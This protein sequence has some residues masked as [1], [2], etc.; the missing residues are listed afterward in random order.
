MKSG[1]VVPVA[2]MAPNALWFFFPAV[3][4]TNDAGVP[5]VAAVFEQVGRI[6]VLVIPFFHTL[7]FRRRHAAVV[8][9]AM[10]AALLVYYA[11]WVRFFADGRAIELFSAPFAGIPVPM[12][13]APSIFLLL[14]SY[15]MRS[16]PMLAGSALFAV[17]HVWVSACSLG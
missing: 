1:F 17:F 9:G 6:A 4:Q 11:C 16:W 7:H 8:A 12:A 10:A 15:L 13:T 3:G 2:L 14:S 5:A